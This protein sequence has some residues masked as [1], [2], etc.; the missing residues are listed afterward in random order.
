MSLAQSVLTRRGDGSRWLLFG[1]LALN[2]FFI[3]I[4][5]ALAIRAPEPS[6]WHNDVFVRTERLA[7]SLPA[8][9]S[10]LLRGEMEARR[11]AIEQAQ[12]NYHE[13]RDN[14]RKALRHEP[15]DAN[16]LDAVMTRARAARQNFDQVIHGVFG[17]AAA[18]MSAEGRRGVADWRPGGQTRKA[19]G[20]DN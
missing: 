17:A 9:D 20:K 2:L 10:A 11:A 18:K 15:F 3:G 13:A 14:I 5:L 8:A 16:A 19:G 6:R 12:K 7:A 4:A 1:S